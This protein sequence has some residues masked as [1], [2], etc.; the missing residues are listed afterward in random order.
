[1]KTEDNIEKT[2]IEFVLEKT[3]P[4]TYRYAEQTPDNGTPTVGTLYI[5]K[6]SNLGKLEGKSLRV[7][8]EPIETA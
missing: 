6:G 8:I 7:T 1:M 4:G 2:V 5:K 3:T